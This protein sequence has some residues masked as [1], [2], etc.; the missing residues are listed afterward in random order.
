[1]ATYNFPPAD[2]TPTQADALVRGLCEELGLDY[3]KVK[4]AL[5][6]GSTVVRVALMGES[7][8]W[9]EE[10]IRTARAEFG[11]RLPKTVDLGASADWP[12][13]KQVL[14]DIGRLLDDGV[15]LGLA[16]Q[17]WVVA[18]ANALSNAL[19]EERAGS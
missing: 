14:I 12:I 13:N 10:H 16:Q 11:Q 1:M 7:G 4:P 18:A 17:R 2:L 15:V 5:D 6:A 9:P 3:S 8:G 19:E